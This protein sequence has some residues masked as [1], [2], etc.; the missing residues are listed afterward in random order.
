[1]NEQDKLQKIDVKIWWTLIKRVVKRRG[2]FFGMLAGIAAVALIE[3]L[4]PMINSRAMELFFE[5]GDYSKLGLYIGLMVGMALI[6]GLGVMVY[7]WCGEYLGANLQVDIRH[8]LFEKL[9][10]LSYS[11]Y[12]KN[13]AGWIMARMTSDTNKIAM[14]LT[15]TLID[16][17]WSAVSL[18]FVFTFMLFKSWRLGL[19][20]LAIFPI[21]FLLVWLIRRYVLNAWRR[22][23]QTNSYITAAYNEEIIGAR[24]TK[25][26]VL[27]VAQTENFQQLTRKMQR[28]TIRAH[29]ISGI[30]W[31]L[32]LSIGTLVVAVV[33]NVGS[34]YIIAGMFTI[35]TLYIFM[36]YAIRLM[37]MLQNLST[38]ILDVQQ[39]Q[40]S[41]ERII[42]LLETK[43]DI[44]DR[45]DVIEKYGTRKAP[46]REN[47]EAMSGAVTF[48]GVDFAYLPEEPIL[49]DFN[50]TVP[51]G[52]TVALVGATGG[53]KST[54]VNLLARFYEPVSGEILI[55][56]RD[57]RERSVAWLH[58]N[59]GYVLQSPHL[60]KGTLA[61]NIRYGKLEATDAEVKAAAEASRVAQFA[62]R[63]P[64][65]LQTDVG[66]NGAKLS[67]G[68]RQLVSFARA[69]IRDPKILI[70]DEAT[71]SIDTETEQAIQEVT[72][73][74]LSGRTSFVVAHR[75]STITNADLILVIE[76]G[77][78]LEQGTHKEL[79]KKKGKYFE[80]YKQQFMLERLQARENG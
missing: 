9:Q 27:E 41:A 13:P 43:P 54:I 51:Q 68:E 36:S 35:P 34:K 55:D 66:E 58:E 69:L 62:A 19:I 32:I 38:Q 14:T 26:L 22:V 79:L 37:D 33:L 18:V 74:L 10:D 16:L 52:A 46:R 31:P 72:E 6:F 71:S 42:G 59:I 7:V 8:D 1:M 15:W 76:G 17:L 23:R 39:A 67:Q 80:L 4:Q 28:Q 53:G 64:E 65:G 21:M 70:L 78:I 61:D 25:T 60:F 73:K 45:P 56:G 77:R 44:V 40:A 11:Y 20:M 63:L 50:L 57:Y 2:I 5:R 12:D 29:L 24:T 49:T 47:W 48:R 3:A 30:V 75:L